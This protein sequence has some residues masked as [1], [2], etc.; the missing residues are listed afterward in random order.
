MSFDRGSGRLFL[1]DVGQGSREEVDI[2]TRGGNYGWNTMEGTSCYAPASGC[3]TAGLDLPI[4]DYGHEE[5]QSITG[6]FV[7]RGST[8]VDFVGKYFFGDFVSGKLWI[9]TENAGSWS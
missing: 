8:L 9:L 6:G 7:Y 3:I 1:A 2:I 5:G 4:A